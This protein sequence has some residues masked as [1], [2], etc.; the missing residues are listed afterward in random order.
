MG[1]YICQSCVHDCAG[2]CQLNNEYPVCQCSNY[3][4]YDNGGDIDA[5][6]EDFDMSVECPKCGDNAYWT[7]DCY[8]CSNDDCGCCFN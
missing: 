3:V 2:W 8:E 4:E 1:D 6:E 7:G 5:S